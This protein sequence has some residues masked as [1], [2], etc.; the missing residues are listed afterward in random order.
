MKKL[1]NTLF[2][3]TQ[4]AYLCHEG[5]AVLV[6]VE[7][8]TKLRLPVHTLG[9]IVCFGQVSCS[10]PL[11]SL[12]SERGVAI[13]FL[14]EQGRFLARV[15]GRVSGNVLLR[16]EQY[17][18]ADSADGRLDLA[19]TFVLAK[20]A[21]ARLVLLRAGRDHGDKPGMEC[22][23]GAARRLGVLLDAARRE[24]DVAAL[25]GWRAMRPIPISG[26]SIPCLRRRRRIS[27]SGYEAG[28]HHWIM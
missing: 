20:I 22:M 5:E 4:G 16:R 2:V 13:S 9:G 28:G 3:T 19:R 10:P 15:E 27:I 21:N 8:E 26:P 1:L 6:R 18:R 17:R 25:K 7:R 14:S 24:K 23:D 12:C 11:M